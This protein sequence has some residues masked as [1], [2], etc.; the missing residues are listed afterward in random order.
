MMNMPIRRRT[1]NQLWGTEPLQIVDDDK[2]RLMDAFISVFLYVSRP[3][4]L[5][6]ISFYS[7]IDKQLYFDPDIRTKFNFVILLMGNKEQDKNKIVSERKNLVQPCHC[8]TQ[9]VP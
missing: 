8:F 3:S 7:F 5:R 9:Q 1:K 2:F 6:Y 4:L